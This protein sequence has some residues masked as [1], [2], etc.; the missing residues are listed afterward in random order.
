MANPKK[1]RMRLS[2]TMEPVTFYAGRSA[3]ISALSQLVSHGETAAGNGVKW[4]EV[5]TAIYEQGLKDGQKLIIEQ[6]DQIKAKAHFQPPG[7]PKRKQK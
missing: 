5:V 4:I 7:R 6:L 3:M 1:F 2:S